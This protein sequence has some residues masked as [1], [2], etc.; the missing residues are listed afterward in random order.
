MSIPTHQVHNVLAAYARRLHER[1][2]AGYDE[3]T[4]KPENF[5]ERRRA[6]IQKMTRH[7]I[8]KAIGQHSQK[9]PQEQAALRR[10]SIAEDQLVYHELEA[11]RK[12]IRLCPARRP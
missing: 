3:N 9:N 12:T 11:G 2:S 6:L 10:K 1:R 4:S 8:D 7:F 5:G